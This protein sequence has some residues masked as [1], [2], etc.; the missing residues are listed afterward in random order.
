MDI[1][2]QDILTSVDAISNE[3]GPLGYGLPL[4]AVHFCDIY[5]CYP[6]EVKE[7]DCSL[8]KNVKRQYSY[9][10]KDGYDALCN[11]WGRWPNVVEMLKCGQQVH[12]PYLANEY[13]LESEWPEGLLFS[14]VE[15]R[16]Y[17][18]YFIV[19]MRR[20]LLLNDGDM[21][22]YRAGEYSIFHCYNFGEFLSCIDN[23]LSYV[24]S[25]Q[26]KFVLEALVYIKGNTCVDDGEGRILLN[27][28]IDKISRICH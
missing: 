3:L 2:V 24:S 12:C 22:I 13:P 20:F 8:D 19:W 14:L 25:G 16:D 27:N 9:M 7:I 26:A 15:G 5:E 1:E 23:L 21:E 4:G 28:A 11:A 6:W 18:Y 17:F 10:L